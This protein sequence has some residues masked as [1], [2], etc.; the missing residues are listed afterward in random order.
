MSILEKNGC[1]LKSPNSIFFHLQT[2]AQNNFNHRN[3]VHDDDLLN[4]Y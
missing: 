1:A 3:D 2:R 4:I